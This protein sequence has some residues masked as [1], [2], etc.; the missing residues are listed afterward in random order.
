MRTL[1]GR[2][3]VK[4]NLVFL[5][6]AITILY[7][8]T[9]LLAS[10]FQNSKLEQNYLAT[11]EFQG[12][13]HLQNSENSKL[14]LGVE[15]TTYYL[16]LLQGKK[17]ALVANQTSMVN[18]V[19]LLDTLLRLGVDVVKVFSP[20]HGFRGEA[21]AGKYVQSAVDPKTGVEIVSLYGKNKKPST[22]ALANIDIVIFDIQDVGVRFY[23]YLSTMGY[24]MDVVAEKGKKMI[25]L[26]RPNP[27]GSYVDGPILDMKN[28]S[29][30]GLYPVPIVHGLTLGEFAQM[31]VGE[32]YLTSVKPLDL[33]VVSMLNYTHATKYRLPV[34]PSPNLRSMEAIYAYPSLCL[35]E[36]TPISVGRGTYQP[37]EIYG[38][39]NCPQAEIT[40]TPKALEGL[41]ANPPFKNVECK[42]FDLT[43]TIEKYVDSNQ[44]INLSY[45]ID[46]YNV[47]PDKKNFFIPFFNKLSGD[48]QLQMQIKNGWT[49]AQIRASWE[50]GLSLYKEKRAR[51]L[52]YA[53]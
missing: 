41:S 17:V 35:F 26:D 3:V 6:S 4:R 20:E 28:S 36:G 53:E 8:D 52:L 22:E 1:I 23:T 5:L 15:R 44:Q 46:M 14:V 33:V 39:P 30:V 38:F 37:F 27:H 21:E 19:H 45:L 18:G 7:S 10:E 31:I 42:G 12:S 40:F 24:M 34:A 49:E 13:Q 50:S 25:I 32:N 48:E 47:Y 11:K 43:K 2:I 29:F 9:T 51:Y 16:P